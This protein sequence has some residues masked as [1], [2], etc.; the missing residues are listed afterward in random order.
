[1]KHAEIAKKSG[2]C[3]PC[4]AHDL[5]TVSEGLQCGNCSAVTRDKGRTWERPS[6]PV[7]AE[8]DGAK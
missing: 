8:K 6:K 3:R 1:M 2:S 5:F 7:K 4:S